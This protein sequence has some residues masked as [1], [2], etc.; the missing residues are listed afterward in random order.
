MQPLAERLR[1]AT[2][3]QYIG[4]EH[5]VGPNAILRKM[6]ESGNVASFILWGPPG[7]GK[8]SIA[9]SIA[10]AVNRNYVRVSLGGVRDEAE[11]RGHRRTYIGAIP[12]KIIYMMKQ[13]DCCNPVMLLDEI[14]KMGKDNRGDPAS[15]MLEVLDPEQNF[16]FYDHYLEAPYDLSKVLFVCT[17][18]S[19]ETIPGPLRDRM[20][21]IK[22]SGYTEDEKLE[23]VK[24]INDYEFKNNLIST[25]RSLDY[26]QS[27]YKDD[28]LY[29]IKREGKTNEN[30]EILFLYLLS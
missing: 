3:D 8:T 20:E 23:I 25:Y 17:A 14:D 9:K 6:I 27:V 21:I 2:L 19:L 5:L 28:D 7:V 1:P 29:F 30:N 12:G 13:A 10:R 4:Q 24:K 16:S 15:A 26:L 18:N 11:I 22:I